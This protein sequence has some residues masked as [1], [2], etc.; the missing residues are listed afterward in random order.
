[1][2]YNHFFPETTFFIDYPNFNKYLFDTKPYTVVI[3]RAVIRELD[4]LKKSEVGSTKD[5]R[6]KGFRVREASR[7]IEAIQHGRLQLPNDGK[8][9]IYT[10]H[11]SGTD[12]SFDEEI[13]AT[14]KRYVGELDQNE[15]VVLLSSDRNLRILSRSS[16]SL[17]V[18]DP[19][20]WETKKAQ[21]QDYERRVKQAAQNDE[22]V[23]SAHTQRLS[24]EE[25]LG[26]YQVQE[27]NDSAN[28]LLGRLAKVQQQEGLELERFEQEQRALKAEKERKT[29]LAIGTNTL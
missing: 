6:V 24:L 25:K 17:I 9:V 16:E 19:C 8:L 14:A 12:L 22:Q 3:C 28:Q 7:T 2:T 21:E 11:G 4:G 5:E 13:E 10:S 18:A 20:D 27:T 15:A 23:R 29:R 26:K 1:M